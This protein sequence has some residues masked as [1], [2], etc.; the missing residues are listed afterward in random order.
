MSHN[1]PGGLKLI[2][3]IIY[4]LQFTNVTIMRFTH[5]KDPFT[6]GK[7]ITKH[8]LEFANRTKIKRLYMSSNMIKSIE[9]GSIKMFPPNLET[10]DMSDN[11]PIPGAY[12]I[13]LTKLTNLKTLIADRL[14]MYHVLKY[15][16]RHGLI[17]NH[18]W[19][20]I[21]SGY[22]KGSKHYRLENQG[23]HMTSCTYLFVATIYYEQ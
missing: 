14:N 15:Q 9:L 8:D 22:P 16:N 17:P 6:V 5:M 2:R 18:C 12:I 20:K 11:R 10:F 21:A 23:S 1:F 7:I 19:V 3:N 13:E 4:G